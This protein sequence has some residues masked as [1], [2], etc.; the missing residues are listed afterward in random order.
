MSRKQSQ[1]DSSGFIFDLQ[2]N[3]VLAR[4]GTFENMKEKINAVRA[5]VPNKSNNEIILVLQ[6]FDNCV[7]KTVQAFMEGSASEV[8]KEWIVKG[9]KKNKKKKSK[10]KPA[11]EASSSVPDSSKSVPVQEEQPASSEKGDI[12]GYHINGAIN[13]ADSADSLS[14]GLETLSID[15]RELE[16]PEFAS[17]D[18]LDRTGS[19]LENGVSELEPRTTHSI[20][21]VQQS[22]NAAKSL[23]RAATGTQASHLGMENVPLSSTN[24]KLGSNIEKSVK[25]LQR[26]TVSLARYRVVVKE[27]MD[28]SIKKMKQ[29]FAE[30][31]SCLMDR[32]VALLAEMDKV[33]AEA[34]EILLSRQKKAELLKKMTDVAVRMSGEQLVELRAD[35]KHFVSERKYDEDLGRVARFT[36]DVETLKQSIDA[37]G[38]VSHPKNSYSTRSRCSS[39]VPVS[40]GGPSDGSAA[41]SS[42]GA[43]APSLTGA[44]KR[45]C[46]PG[47]ASAATTN[48]SEQPCQARREVFSGNRRGGQGYRPQSQ[49]TTDPTSQGQPDSVGRYRNSSRYSSGSRHQNTPP[50]APGNT[51]EWSQAYSAGTNGTGA[52]MAPS[53]PKPSFKRGL[54]QRKPRTSQAEA[55]NS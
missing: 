20:P 27:E 52:S 46:A 33:K 5:I 35:I 47:E 24:K 13:D 22:R 12:N 26:C 39:V 17:P 16:D 44:N 6:H 10:P 53:P 34:M 32:E 25:D 2:S 30:L 8:L 48:S 14:E 45:G 15:A 37:F 11:S 21:N 3:T 31:Q 9:K 4:G 51:S 29:A 19:V 18:T 55:V 23:S 38:Q 28:A 49:K 54:P 50:Q 42:S 7:D 36:C 41:S 43:S 40:L 1:K